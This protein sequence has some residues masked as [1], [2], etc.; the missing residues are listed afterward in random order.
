MRGFGHASTI[1]DLVVGPERVVQQSGAQPVFPGQHREVCETDEVPRFL[2][3]VSVAP[4]DGARSLE[5]FAGRREV[6][7]L[8]TDQGEIV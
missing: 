7:Q 5:L 1:V 3:T 4:V 6:A 2:G 8:D